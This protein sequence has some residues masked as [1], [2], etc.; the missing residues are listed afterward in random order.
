MADNERPPE[1]TPWGSER[2]EPDKFF[3]KFWWIHTSRHGGLYL[4][5]QQ[6]E[7]IPESLKAHSKNGTGVWWE[8]NTAWSLPVICLLA[9]RPEASLSEEE[10]EIFARAH[11][12]AQDEYPDEWEHLTGRKIEP[13]ESQRR[14]E[15]WKPS[16]ATLDWKA[17]LAKEAEVGRLTNDENH[18]TVE[19]L[20]EDPW[21]VL[22]HPIPRDADPQVLKAARNAAV[23]CKV[24]AEID[25]SDSAAVKKI[26][27]IL[28]DIRQRLGEPEPEPKPIDPEM[29]TTLDHLQKTWS[30]QQP[31]DEEKRLADLAQ[32]YRDRL[33]EQAKE[34][35]QTYKAPATS[36]AHKESINSYLNSRAQYADHWRE[37]IRN[38]DP[39]ITENPIISADKRFGKESARHF[40]LETAFESLA[41][42]DRAEYG[43]FNWQQNYLAERISNAPDV[44][45][46]EVLKTR[47]LIEVYEYL[48][49]TANHIA[50][51]SKE[52]TG[53][54]DNPE[55]ISMTRA[56]GTKDS[57]G[58]LT[59]ASDLYE[60]YCELQDERAAEARAQKAA[61]K[62]K[63][64]L[65]RLIEE[66]D[67]IARAKQDQL[68]TERPKDRERDRER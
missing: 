12:T 33:I 67:R 45:V 56:A 5:A 14:D 2:D 4:T 38:R 39:D 48:N 47:K 68:R 49:R 54:P 7:A 25:H 60:H 52:I 62:P 46:Q 9:K 19:R 18:L 23:V 22:E 1:E 30:P 63:D 42:T 59:R 66:Q 61:E 21:L 50:L 34:L 26:D 64:P 31:S 35:E 32:Q 11:D 20:S 28:T 27:A 55:S 40:H 17:A 43:T 51:Q 57:A 3:G 29:K 6:Q 65:D 37:L 8:E 41:E 53:H 15:N 24:E 44:K 58:Y 10:Q 36:E 13:G 16:S